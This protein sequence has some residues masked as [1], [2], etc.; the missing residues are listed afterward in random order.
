MSVLDV[1]QNNRMESSVQELWGKGSTPSVSLLPGASWF[2]VLAPN[3]IPSMGEI[4]LFD[5]LYSVQKKEL[6]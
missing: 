1:A 3:R 6:W 2:R 5:K 4:E